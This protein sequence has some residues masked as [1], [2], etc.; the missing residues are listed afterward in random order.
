MTTDGQVSAEPRPSPYVTRVGVAQV[1]ALFDAVTLGVCAA[2]ITAITVTA[3]LFHLAFIDL[4]SGV[5]WSSYIVGCA[6]CH[7]LLCFTY[8]RAPPVGEHWRSWA[9]W[10]SVI[11]LAEGIGWG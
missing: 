3:I 11:S 5:M 9:V 1:D 2:A 10:F 6:V 7:I 4:Q 8:R